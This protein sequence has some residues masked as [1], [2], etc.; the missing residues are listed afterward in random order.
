[1][2]E[3]LIVR[4][5][6]QGGGHFDSSRTGGRK[7][8]GTDYLVNEGDSIYMPENGKVIRK[9]YP[10]ASDTR[11][12]GL[13][14]RGESGLEYKVF[15]MVPLDGI[16]GKTLKK[17][18]LIGHAQAISEKYSSAMKDHIHVYV[19]KDGNFID[20]ETILKPIMGQ[21][22]NNST[23][24]NCPNCGASLVVSEKNI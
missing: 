15:Y 21:K 17:G 13:Y 16:T 11:W 7:H 9:S 4:N 12:Q 24:F 18:Q 10:Y 2:L 3:K 1:M 20:P 14:I 6:S 8:N 23:C 22:K 19:I 5:D